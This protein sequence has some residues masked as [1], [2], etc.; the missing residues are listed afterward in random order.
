MAT[1]GRQLD[2]AETHEQVLD[3]CRNLLAELGNPRA[4]SAVRGAA[5]LDR[6]LGLGSLERVELMVRLDSAFGTRLPDQAV[7]EADTIDDLVAAVAA[8]MRATPVG[9]TPER[10]ADKQ[11]RIDIPVREELRAAP[12]QAQDAPGVAPTVFTTRTD[13]GVE[14]AETLQEVLRYRARFDGH[15]PHLI[16]P[17]DPSPSLG[18]E[19]SSAALGAG[20]TP[21]S[22]H[23]ITTF[24]ELYARAE[25]V[26]Q[27]LARRGVAPGHT[28]AIMLPTSPEFFYTFA[29]IL[30]AG[31]IPV[32]IYPPFR[33]ARIAEYAERQSAILHNAE[34]RLLVTFRQAETGARLLQPRV[35]SPQGVVSATRLAETPAPRADE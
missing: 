27:E 19:S 12:G 13:R 33:A 16:F 18:T 28:V 11:A 10:N 30:L 1:P 22:P 31:A 5:H 17:E 26:A 6:D 20:E 25:T 34:A 23:T 29:G 3:I 14:A 21:N 15:R 4:L 8:A 2:L 35:P 32:P 9:G 24:G 7:A